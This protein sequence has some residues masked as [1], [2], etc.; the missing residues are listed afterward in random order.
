MEY[1][2]SN[3][4]A[5]QISNMVVYSDDYIVNPDGIDSDTM[6]VIND[7]ENGVWLCAHNDEI[8]YT[9]FDKI[10]KLA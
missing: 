9:K 1:I 5:E 6:I 2:I 8:E 3:K 4:L 7:F 10:Q